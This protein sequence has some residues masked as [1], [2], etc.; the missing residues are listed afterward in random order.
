MYK[1]GEAFVHEL[2][3]RRSCHSSNV[4]NN[5]RMHA[6]DLDHN[7]PS[8]LCFTLPDFDKA[9]QPVLKHYVFKRGGKVAN[10]EFF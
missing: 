9:L 4:T 2:P 7:I 3:N 5:L 6:E 1:I 10:A 8:G